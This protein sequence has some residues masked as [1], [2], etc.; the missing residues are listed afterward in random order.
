[1]VA[2]PNNAGGTRLKKMVE[3][4]GVEVEQA[5]K[6]HFRIVWTLRASHADKALIEKNK[7]A[8][9]L[10]RVQIENE[11]RWTI[12]GLFGWDKADAG[13]KFLLEH[14]PKDISGN[15][16]DFGCGYGYLSFMVAKRY[17]A[18]LSVDAY[19]ADARAVE[20]CKRN[21]TDKV[22]A[23]W[24]NIPSMDIRKRYDAIIMNPPFH[25]GKGEDIGLGQAF[26]TKA[27]HS[28]RLGG[29]LFMVSNRTLPY[30]KTVTGLKV[31]HENADYK[32]LGG[33]A[34]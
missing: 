13:S 25:T 21:S 24:E 2:A 31:L 9:A 20:C 29:R 1:M 27:W 33:H 18:I 15:I 26:I 5:S 10:R 12:P 3:A 6:S 14:L 34:P 16:A 19:D 4:Y 22:N 30:E 11:D 8:L 23:L 32:I 17:P 7:A 28:L